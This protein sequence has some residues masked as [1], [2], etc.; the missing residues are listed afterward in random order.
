MERA[1]VGCREKSTGPKLT[2]DARPWGACVVA[3]VS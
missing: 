1:E 3:L 2:W